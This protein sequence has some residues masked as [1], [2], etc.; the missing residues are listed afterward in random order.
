MSDP[1]NPWQ[2]AISK[3]G[4][5]RQWFE[6]ARKILWPANRL[7]R[8]TCQKNCTGNRGSEPDV[9]PNIS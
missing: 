5:A 9:L 8:A 6:A 3:C 7:S 1:L 2:D 4:P